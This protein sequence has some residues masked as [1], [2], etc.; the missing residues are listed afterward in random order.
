MKILFIAAEM[1]PLVKVGGLA[2]VVR[3]L[4]AEL[5]KRG[6]DAYVIIPKYGFVD[7]SQY[8]ITPVINDLVVFS[9]GEYRKVSVEALSVEGLRVYLLGGDIFSRT[10]SVYGGD[11]IEKF[12]VFCE[13]V[14]EVMPYLG[15][16]PEIIHCHD[17]HTALLPLLVRNCYPSC[18]SVFTIHN[19]GY[20]G[21]FD[22]YTLYRSGLGGYWQASLSGGPGIPRNFLA[23]GILWAHMI[24][25]VSET[26]AREILTPEQGYGMQELLQ[27]RK[28]S[29]TGIINGL[30]GG[31]YDPASDMLISTTYTPGDLVGKS[32]NKQALQKAAG[33]Q[34]RPEVPVVG[35]V[36]RLDEQKGIDIIVQS[37]SAVL[38]ETDMQFVFLGTGKEYYERALKDL[39][40]A[41]PYNIKAFITFDDRL[42]HLIYAGA[43]MFLMPSLWEPCGL[44]QMIAM[45]YGT[46]PV[47]RK[48]GGLADT[49]S[50]LSSDLMSGN[51][52]V[53]V[54]YSAGALISTLKTAVAAFQK[55]DAWERVVT[56][57]MQQDFSWRGPAE[58]YE[59]LYKRAMELK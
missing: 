32:L 37:I 25:A 36:S 46:V 13:S 53:F 56:R 44:G 35:M 58:K 40:V 52:F 4:P 11:E 2:D 26:Y 22:E 29:L 5:N 57:I 20:Q 21:N 42:A 15:W 14:C 30:D 18:R 34:P 7:Y 31:E 47:V 39:E 48:V 28:D 38:T 24:N 51:G 41:Y 10:L 1:A 55:K 54:D 50:N 3:S 49:V 16:Q 27:F 23:Q 59:E 43:D 9:L 17:W 19:V 33:L 8:A 6:H 12:F 45:K